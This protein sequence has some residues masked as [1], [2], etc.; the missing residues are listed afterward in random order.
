MIMLVENFVH[1]FSTGGFLSTAIFA[2]VLALVNML[3]GVDDAK[4]S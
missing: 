4:H 3:F 2:I 1:G